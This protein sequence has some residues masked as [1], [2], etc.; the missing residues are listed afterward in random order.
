VRRVERVFAH[1]GRLFGDHVQHSRGDLFE[2]RLTIMVNNLEVSREFMRG[3]SQL[4]HEVL[5]VPP[6]G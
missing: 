4:E 5:E 2:A 1:L 6:Q 3:I